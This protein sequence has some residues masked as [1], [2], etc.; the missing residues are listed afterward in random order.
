M[1]NRVIEV[2]RLS[3]RPTLQTLANDK[4]KAFFVLAVNRSSGTGTDF[5]PMTAWGNVA[6]NIYKYCDKGSLISMEGKI[7]TSKYTDNNNSVQ[8]R[9]EIVCEHVQ[10]IHT[11]SPEKQGQKETESTTQEVINVETEELSDEELRAMLRSV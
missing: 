1:L 9:M 5:I 7:T 3:V 8:Y 2:G 6:E 11:V 10:F 4:K